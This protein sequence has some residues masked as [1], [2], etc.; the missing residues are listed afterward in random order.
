VTQAA[1]REI[2][3]EYLPTEKNGL[4]RDLYRSLGF[5]LVSTDAHGGRQVWRDVSAAGRELPKKHAEL[6]RAA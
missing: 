4:V 2:V 1:G 6:R 3:G 5:E